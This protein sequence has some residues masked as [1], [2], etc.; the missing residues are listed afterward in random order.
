MF[1]LFMTTGGFGSLIQGRG[2]NAILRSARQ[3][4]REMGYVYRIVRFLCQYRR[5]E[6]DTDSKF[7]IDTAKRFLELNCH[8]GA[9]TFGLSKI[10]KIWEKNRQAAPYMFAFY[11]YLSRALGRAKSVNDAVDFLVKLSSNPKHLAK[12]LGWAA[13]AAD[14][15]EARARRVRVGDFKQIPRVEPPL[16]RFQPDELDIIKSIN[17]HTPIP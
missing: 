16:P 2:P 3:A 4:K 15:L 9:K 6:K 14:V 8:E 7:S 17:P 5:Y 1:A 12:I 13:Y 11:R 10:S